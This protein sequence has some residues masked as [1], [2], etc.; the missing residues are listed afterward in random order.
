VIS[1]ETRRKIALTKLG[2]KN[3][4]WK[5]DQCAMRTGNDRARRIFKSTPPCM[6]CGAPKSE[7]HH[8]DGNP[9]NNAQENIAFLCRRH[10][11]EA[12]GRLEALRSLAPLS[13]PLASA[14]RSTA[15]TTATHCKRGH[16]V[17]MATYI[18]LL[19]VAER[20][21]LNVKGSIRPPQ[22]REDG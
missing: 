13:Q 3:P 1:D 17:A 9:R 11:M 10:H 6:K 19:E 12:D 21:V 20:C 4:N 5:G 14:V 18:V 16:C 7:R 8:I 2:P 22:R 15:Q